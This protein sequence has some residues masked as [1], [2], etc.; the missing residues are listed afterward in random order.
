MNI[1]VVLPD[2]SLDAWNFALG[3]YNKASPK[4]LTLPEYVNDIIVGAQTNSN[5]SAYASYQL[6]QLVPLGEK[7]NAAPKSVQEQI[8]A[9]LSPFNP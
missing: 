8:D 7:Y 6:T 9:L 3:N 4:A 5:V 2:D 1:L